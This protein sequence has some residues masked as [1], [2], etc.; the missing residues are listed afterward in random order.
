MDLDALELAIAVPEPEPVRPSK[1]SKKSKDK[2]DKKLSKEN[3]KRREKKP[4]L[5][6]DLFSSLGLHTVDELLAGGDVNDL[7]PVSEQYSEVHTEGDSEYEPTSRSVPLR[8]ILSPSPR[9]PT[10]RSSRSRVRLSLTDLRE[11]RSRSASPEAITS[12]RARTY[13]EDFDDESI[14]SEVIRT[15]TIRS[16]LMRTESIHT[17]EGSDT[18]DYSERT[19]SPSPRSSASFR[20]QKSEDYY[21]DDFTSGTDTLSP[22]RKW[23]SMGSLYST[24]TDTDSFSDTSTR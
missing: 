20:R 1:L 3:K 21:S 17:I 4:K 23:S 13:S 5:T 19:L 10:P 15:D 18:E 9:P 8:S 11:E 2:Q 14:H 16:E 12:S 6:D 7:E 22:R 24:Y